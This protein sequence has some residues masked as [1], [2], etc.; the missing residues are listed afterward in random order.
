MTLL[1]M[2]TAASKLI[3]FLFLSILLITC[4]LGKSPAKDFEH[5]EVEREKEQIFHLS[6]KELVELLPVKAAKHDLIDPPT[7]YPT[8]PVTTPN[9]VPPDN[10]APTIVT[11][12]ATNPNSGFPNPGSTP[13][14]VPS[15]TPV[16]VPNT[17]PVNSPL[18]ITNPVTTPSTNPPVSNPVTTN[19]SPPVGGV[20]VIT[21]VTPP[22]TTNAPIAPGQSWCVAKNGAMETALQSA[23][24]YACGMGGANCLAIQQG[25]SCYN[26]NTMQNHA[27]YAFNSYFQKNPT[28]TSCDF[29]GTAMITNSN[30]STGS[31]IFPNSASS[32]SSPVTSTPTITTP[33]AGTAVPTTSSTTGV[34]VPGTGAPPTVLNASNP[35]LGEMPTGFGDTIPPTVT[36][37]TSMS[38]S[39]KPFISCIILFTSLMTV[40][41]VLDI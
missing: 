31:C 29:G 27:S 37:S 18:P 13:L 30:P 35:A 25:G 10:S 38:S 7:V 11:V 16:S 22:A 9:N 36:T 6:R 28:Q 15:T 34:A 17:N 4:I 5:K 39:L 3:F 19:P 8:T 26:P 23:L 2:A 41:L 1:I 14:A 24:D 21:P 40:K 33:S 32:T 20:P 12:P